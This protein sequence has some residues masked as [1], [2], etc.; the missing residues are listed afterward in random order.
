IRNTNWGTSGVN[1]LGTS[2]KNV[3]SHLMGITKYAIGAAKALAGMVGLGGL[4]GA[5]LIGKGLSDYAEF[6]KKINLLMNT[7]APGTSA[8]SKNVREAMEKNMR[9]M[10]IRTGATAAD[11]TDAQTQLFSADVR[12]VPNRDLLKTNPDEYNRQLQKTSSSIINDL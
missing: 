5:G 6:N 12:F 4:G 7:L 1:N 2:L 9:Q 8:E 10:A 3:S 11:V